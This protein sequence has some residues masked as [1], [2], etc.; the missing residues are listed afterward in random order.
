[1]KIKEVAN[2]IRSPY[3]Y[4]DEDLYHTIDI[5]EDV[6]DKEV[7]FMYIDNNRVKSENDYFAVLSIV[8]KK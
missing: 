3:L 4:I 8:T 1:M 5:P 7:G 2:V 6:G